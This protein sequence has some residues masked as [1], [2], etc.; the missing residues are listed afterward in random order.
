MLTASAVGDIAKIEALVNEDARLV[1]AKGQVNDSL[2][3][4][5]V[6]ALDWAVMH[7]Q[8]E[9]IKLLIAAGADINAPNDGMTPLQSAIDLYQLPDYEYDRSM[10]DFL[11]EQ[12][13]QMD[14][15]SALFLGDSDLVKQIIEEDPTVVHARGPDNTTPLCFAGP[16]EA[17][18]FL[19]YGANPLETTL[20][21]KRD[22]PYM[23]GNPIQVLA[24]WPAIDTIR[25]LLD[26][27]NLVVDGY[28]A[29]VLNEVEAVMKSVQ[30]DPALVHA[31]TENGHVL[32][33]GHRLL[34]LAV[35]YNMSDLVD[36]L[37]ARGADI[38]A[39]SS[40]RRGMMPLHVAAWRNN[41][42]LAK[43]LIDQGADLQ[44][45]SGLDQLT[46]LETAKKVYSDG[47][48]RTKMIEFFQGLA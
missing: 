38:H 15:F 4:G 37:L 45:R 9:V 22:T 3:V 40:G 18:L 29:V 10:I 16:E 20:S 12:G 33:V 30:S 1:Q 11:M 46:P 13:A 2:W 21:E 32:G 23:H 6:N 36:F 25:V 41:V 7:Q 39:Q 31:Q 44:A 42:D 43:L 19:A 26:H 48:L 8:K 34:H 35:Y 28:L 17:K 24:R 14:I 27:L 47:Q 5:D